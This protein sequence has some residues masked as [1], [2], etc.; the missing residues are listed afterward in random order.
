VEV[1]VSHVGSAAVAAPEGAV[2]T[3]TASSLRE[4]L[5]AAMTSR[6]PSATPASDAAAPNALIVD[7]SRVTFLDSSGLGVLSAT[8]HRA[9]Q[10]GCTFSIAEPSP[11]VTRMLAIT[12]L[13]R[14]WP[15]F[16]SLPAALAAVVADGS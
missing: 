6:V 4:K 10:L 7:L 2:D 15:V 12:S 13:D 1:T 16:P 14:A 5:M 11:T 3:G 9:R 8:A